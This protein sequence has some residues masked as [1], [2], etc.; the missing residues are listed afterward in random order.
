MKPPKKIGRNGNR[1]VVHKFTRFFPALSFGGSA[2]LGGSE[3]RV[4]VLS[5]DF[6]CPA[7]HTAVFY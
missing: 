7:L 4:D 5:F 3:P 1:N 6:S 2:P